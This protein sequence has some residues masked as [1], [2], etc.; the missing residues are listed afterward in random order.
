MTVDTQGK[1][2]PIHPGIYGVAFLL[3][4]EEWTIG[5][6][7]RR[8]G[9]NSLSRYNWTLGNATNL[10]RDW[11]F[12]NVSYGLQYPRFLTEDLDHHVGSALTVPILGW[13]S[14]D[15]TSVGFPKSQF[16]AQDSF[17]PYRPE[18]GN[19][20]HGGKEVPPGPPTTTSTPAPPDFVRKWVEAI[21]RTDQG[22]GS[23]SVQEY[24]LD[25][26]PNLW[27]A[28]HRDVHPEPLTYDELLQRTID[29]GS[30]I[31]AADKEA[32]IAGPAEWGWTGYMYSAKDAAAGVSLRPDRRAHGDV[33][34]MA[35]YL[36]KLHEHE[37]KT[38][39]R[40]IDVFDLH[41][42]PQGRD[43]YS[44]QG[45]KA[46]DALRIRSTRALWDPTYTDESWINEPVRLIPRMKQWVAENYPG[47][48]I[49]IG[50]WNFGG[51]GRMSGGIATAEALGRFAQLEVTAAYYWT[52]PPP[53]SPSY[54]AFRAYRNF[55]GRGGR[56]ED[57]SL[58]TTAAA[59]TS[60]FASRDEHGKHFVLI[61]LN[62]MPDAAAHARIE[63]PACDHAAKREAYVYTGGPLGFPSPKA[64]PPDGPITVDL[65]PYS[66]TV[67][68]VHLPG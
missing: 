30:A 52:H 12:E 22:R 37:Q 44:P 20:L 61:A 10:G 26:E 35:Y 17:D 24:I 9:G 66:I 36:A 7:G 64:L 56:F 59:G 53:G 6:T 43:V 33:P 46:L 48:G 21:R 27:S 28:T 3:E 4:K 1:A 18:A 8:W 65:P 31:R 15:T 19:G 14:K 42:Y 13:V 25:N 11:Y 23:R 32:V 68:D 2:V 5:M 47:L 40:V 55:D 29:Y 16:P 67:I 57:F 51:E 41:F 54:W 34:L 60:L 62:M 45:G 50:E 63:A 58:P 39:T 49:Q 38:G